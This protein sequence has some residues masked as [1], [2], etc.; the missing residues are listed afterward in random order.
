MQSLSMKDLA[1]LIGIKA[2]ALRTWKKHDY[3]KTFFPQ[4]RKLFYD[5]KKLKQL[6]NI[7][8]LH[9]NGFAISRIA[10]LTNEEIQEE[11]SRVGINPTNYKTWILRLLQAAIDVNEAAFVRMLN[12]LSDKIGLKKLIVDV[13]YPYLQRV[14][15]I[16]ERSNT[17]PVQEHFSIY[18]IQNKIISETENFSATQNSEPELV[19][20]CP[21]DAHPD[22]PLLFINYLLR[23]NRWRV[24]YLGIDTKIEDIKEAAQLPGIKYLYVHF[25][26]L[27]SAVSI[28]D[29]FEMLRKTFPNRIIIV[30][31]AGIEQSQRNFVGMYKL[32]R[33]EEIYRFIERQVVSN[34]E[35]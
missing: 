19:L 21:E 17:I 14:E 26:T 24:L 27:Y 12:Q 23:K 1:L 35:Q 7:S 34:G 20:F 18:H 15:L 22:L 3:L 4:K 11:V 31:G 16:W 2:T 30:S 13:C 6:L 9:H 29:Y 32:K 25:L 28:D 33:D 5:D 10:T 8:F